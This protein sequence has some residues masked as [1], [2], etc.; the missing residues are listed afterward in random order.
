MGIVNVTPDSFSDGGLYNN[1]DAALSHALRLI[2]AGADIIDVGGE[3][4]R[5]GA[6]AVTE[7]EEIDRVVP[8]IERI[9]N[10]RPDV[11]LSIDTTK[12]HV[13]KAACD[14]GATMINDISG[15]QFDPNMAQTAAQTKAALVIMH[16]QGKPRT[17]QQSPMYDDVVEDVARIL[18]SGIEQAMAAGVEKTQIIVDPG[19]GFGKT[20]DQNYELIRGLPRFVEMEHMILLGT[21]RKS[22]MGAT[23]DR[24]TTPDERVWATAASVACGIYAGAHIVRVH[25]VAQMY[26][27]VQIAQACCGVLTQ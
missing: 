2:D 6:D 4:T 16:I 10:A 5:P 20:V 1:H 26:D 17:M 23:L 8:V 21:S 11:M 9:H 13:A 12:A 7:Q 14:V 18:T 24:D 22:F 27:V 25:D 15:L 19:I 3:S